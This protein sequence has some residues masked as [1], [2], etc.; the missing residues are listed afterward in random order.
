MFFLLSGSIS[1]LF[2][3]QISEMDKGLVG[4]WI[5]EQFIVYL[6]TKLPKKTYSCDIYVMICKY[7]L[8]LL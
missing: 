4:I 2:R 3:N 1:S 5:S 8:F 7:L 6:K